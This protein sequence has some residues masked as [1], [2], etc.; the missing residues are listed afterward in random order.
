MESIVNRWQ[1]GLSLCSWFESENIYLRIAG[2]D[3]LVYTIK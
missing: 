1:L 2:S 3:M